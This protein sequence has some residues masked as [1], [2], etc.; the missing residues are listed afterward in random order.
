[1][2]GEQQMGE[3]FSISLLMH[4][5][6]YAFIKMSSLFNILTYDLSHVVVVRPSYLELA[7]LFQVR[8][9][10][11]SHQSLRN[12]KFTYFNFSRLNTLWW[13][14]KEYLSCERK[15]TVKCFLLGKGCT[16]GTTFVHCQ[17]TG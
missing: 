7:Y 3:Y 2:L 11:E 4:F 17:V 8:D 9:R 12:L 15:V 5:S 1:M 14:K 6:F 13:S 16:S 10:F